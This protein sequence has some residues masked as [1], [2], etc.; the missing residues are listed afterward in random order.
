VKK[1]QLAGVYEFEWNGRDEKDVQV[2]G[3]LY[4]YRLQTDSY[5]KTRKLLI[6][7]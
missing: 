5:Q 4:F 6:L 1:K 3:G 2:S 7:K